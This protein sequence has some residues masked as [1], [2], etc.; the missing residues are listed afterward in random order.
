[1]P[2]N[3][4]QIDRYGPPEVLEYRSVELPALR[5]GEVR[6][7]TEFAAVNYIE[8]HI[9]AG[10]APIL[11]ASPL[12]YTPGME[13][14]GLIDE[15]A[16]D[17]GQWK[18]GQR[19]ITMM[20]GLAG[21]RAERDGGYAEFVTVE[22]DSLA[23]VP[24]GVDAAD[25]AALGL[26][27]VTAFE[28]LR[29]LGE[30]SSKRIIVTGAAG[31]VGAMATAIAHASGAA[32]VA[33]IRRAQDSDYVRSLGATEVI[34]SAEG[35]VEPQSADGVLDTVAGDLFGPCVKALKPGGTLCL[36]GAVGGGYVSFD[37]WELLRSIRL[38]GYSTEALDGGTLQEA[39]NHL[40]G[41]LISQ[42]IRPPDYKVLPLKD[43]A[44]AHRL[45]ENREV[46]GRVLLALMSASGGKRTFGID[47]S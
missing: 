14:V 29:K 6:V 26:G 22:A 4:I 5:S 30:L 44:S 1:M 43:A 32:V 11:T 19:V 7:K 18:R 35:G 21:V 47:R 10:N 20:Q 31:G 13:V 42:A 37:A 41:M 28:G 34:I 27:A 24:D 8:L 46:R 38:T 2:R 25:M 40:T 15:A 45:L 23:A 33:I 16:A 36:V 3:A 17:V 39:V 9:R 12:P